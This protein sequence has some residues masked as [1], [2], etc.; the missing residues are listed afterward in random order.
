MLYFKLRF[1]LLVTQAGEFAAQL[2]KLA[3]AKLKHLL[4]FRVSAR[5]LIETSLQTRGLAIFGGTLRFEFLDLHLI[6]HQPA[7]LLLHL[8][9]QLAIASSDGLYL[10]FRVN[11]LAFR[12][13]ELGDGVAQIGFQL[14]E[15]TQASGEFALEVLRLETSY[16]TLVY[17]FCKLL[18]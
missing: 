4:K 11:N 16:G 18:F 5:G 10:A 2:L 12:H 3:I 1:K 17:R 13:L 7:S 6:A 9:H 15:P 8:F 14:L